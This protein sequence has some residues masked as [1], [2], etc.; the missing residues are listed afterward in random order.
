[1]K[2]QTRRLLRSKKN[3]SPI[4]WERSHDNTRGEQPGEEKAG[5]EGDGVTPHGGGGGGGGGAE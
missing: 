2:E 4:H 3:P 1:M 5:R